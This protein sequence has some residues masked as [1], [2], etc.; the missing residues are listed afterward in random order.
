MVPSRSALPDVLPTERLN[1]RGVM[2]RP[3]RDELR[4]IPTARNV[5]TTLGAFAQTFGVV[6]RRIRRQ[7]VVGVP[8]R[9]R[10]DGPRPLRAQHPRPRGGAPAAVPEPLRQRRGRSDARLPDVPAVHRLPALALRPPPRRDGS[11]RARHRRCT[12]ATRSR[13]ASWHRKLRRDA[14]GES[15]YKNIKGLVLAARKGVPDAI[16]ILDRP[17]RACSASSIAFERPLAYVVWLALVVHAVEGVE[18]AAGD[19]RARRHGALEGPPPDDARDPP[20]LDR[21]LLHRAR[22]TPAGTSPTTPTWAC[23]GATCRV[24][25]RARGVG[26]GDARHR[27]PVVPGVLAGVLVTPGNCVTALA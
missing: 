14:T 23:R 10:V 16:Q 1:V 21:P 15:A 8:G 11:R 17:G 20:E 9:V 24:P 6:D 19:R 2:V 25:R 7:H 3:W 18:P 4:R 27:V 12:P 5:L 22:T 13:R 26:L